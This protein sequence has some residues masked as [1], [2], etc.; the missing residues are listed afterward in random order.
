[1]NVLGNAD[2]Q[3]FELEHPYLVAIWRAEA[4]QRAKAYYPQSLQSNVLAQFGSALGG[5]WPLR[6][7]G[8]G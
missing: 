2:L 6:R 7:N 1:M 8:N 4:A 5:L 3:I